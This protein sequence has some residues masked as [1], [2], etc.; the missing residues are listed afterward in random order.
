MTVLGAAEEVR[1]AVAI[2]IDDRRADIV[3]FNIALHER[4]LV[5]KNPLLI[6]LSNL[7]QKI[8]I[9]RIQEHIELLIAI[10]VDHAELPAPAPSSNPFTQKHGLAFL[11]AKNTFRRKK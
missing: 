2:K 7:A 9:R 3:P 10:P 5:R 1:D 4:A 6:I 8:R 11:I